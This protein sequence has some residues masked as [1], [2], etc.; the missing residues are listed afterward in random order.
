[1]TKKFKI[2]VPALILTIL[3]CEK[4]IVLDLEKSPEKIVIEGTI[5]N[6]VNIQVVKISK[7][8]GFYDVNDGPKVSNAIVSVTTNGGIPRFYTETSPGNYE[9]NNLMGSPNNTYT[10]SV[11]IDGKEYRATSTMPEAVPFINLIYTESIF[12]PGGSD[13]QYY[14]TPIFLDPA[15]VSN[16]YRYNMEI[17]GKREK[18]IFTQNDDLINGKTNTFG[19]LN[20]DVEIKQGASVKVTMFNID[21]NVY[22][23]FYVLSQNQN[24]QNTPNNPETDFSGNVLGYFSAEYKQ[25]KTISIP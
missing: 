2:L 21:K 11:T 16:Y 23:Y 15:N 4:E 8:T 13:K 10:I 22:N 12:N 14:V 5:S 6:D 18:T 3:S 17:N 7:S 25:E 24:A 20:P 1:M 9:I 19:F